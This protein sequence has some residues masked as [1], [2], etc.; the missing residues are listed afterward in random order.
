M[1]T[2]LSSRVRSHSHACVLALS[3]TMPCWA[4]SIVIATNADSWVAQYSTLNGYSGSDPTNHPDPGAVSAAITAPGFVS[5]TVSVARHGA[6][7]FG[8]ID[9]QRGILRGY[10]S[11]LPG[12]SGSIS[13]LNLLALVTFVNNTGAP[14]LVTFVWNVTGSETSRCIDANC[15]ANFDAGLTFRNGEFH[16]SS[17]QT[18][19]TIATRNTFTNPTTTLNPGL[20]ARFTGQFLI[21]VGNLTDNLGIQ[22]NSQVRAYDQDF[23]NTAIFEIHLPPGVT[24]SSPAGFLSLPPST[25][26]PEPGSLAMA[27]LGAGAMTA[28]Y[29]ARRRRA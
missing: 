16:Y 7:A 10:T 22:L 1:N 6:A 19:G 23:R 26:V 29:I 8:E 4:D 21:P 15:F 12:Q 5:N 27:L 18:A 9:F 11:S 24:F 28:R 3:V 25:A 14:A 13:I 2:R 20:G 17:R